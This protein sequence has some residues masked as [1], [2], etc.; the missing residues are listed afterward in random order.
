MLHVDKHEVDAG[1]AQE[2]PNA[3]GRKFEQ[4]MADFKLLTGKKAFEICSGHCLLYRDCGIRECHLG[5]G[6]A[7]RRIT[8]VWLGG[9]GYVSTAA[10]SLRPVLYGD[11]LHL[12][13]AAGLRPQLH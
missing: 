11:R 5:D 3:R 6:L 13:G 2:L 7:K 1:A 8:A 9:H 12:A 4:G 10:A